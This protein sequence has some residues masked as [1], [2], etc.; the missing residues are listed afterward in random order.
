MVAVHVHLRTNVFDFGQMNSSRAAAHFIRSPQST[1]MSAIGLSMAHMMSEI[2]MARVVLRFDHE[3][4]E[5]FCLSLADCSQSHSSAP[6]PVALLE[7]QAGLSWSKFAG[8]HT[9]NLCPG[10]PRRQRHI[11]NVP[12]R[13][14][15]A[16][17]GVL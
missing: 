8:R 10:P 13:I 4:E 3:L 12:R 7:Q 6:R 11:C 5:F 1:E 2:E 16:R 17:H 15:P 9:H 14:L